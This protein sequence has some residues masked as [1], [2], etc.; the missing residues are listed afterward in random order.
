MRLYVWNID[1]KQL[2]G[3]CQGC[4]VQV[5]YAARLHT[6]PSPQCADESQYNN[7]CWLLY[8]SLQRL[9]DATQSCEVS[10]NETL[11]HVLNDFKYEGGLVVNWVLVGS[12]GRKNR[13]D[14]GGVK[15]VVWL[16]NT[17]VLLQLL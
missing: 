3:M 16:E 9:I 5:N 6:K 14:F 12:A 11:Q 10:R 4:S 2:L 1:K 8:H 13:P 7:V 17:A 15:Y